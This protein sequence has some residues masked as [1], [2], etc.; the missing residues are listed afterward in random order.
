MASNSLG[1]GTSSRSAWTLEQNKQFENALAAYEEGTP[2]RWQCIARA[3]GGKSVEEV[4]RHY[5]ILLEDI[6]KIESDQF[7]LP[8]YKASGSNIIGISNEQRFMKNL[9]LH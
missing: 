4:R 6:R 3:V 1:R 2:D 9:Q 8:N 5:E 7:P